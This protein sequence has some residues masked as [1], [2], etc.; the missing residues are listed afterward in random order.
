MIIRK[1]KPEEL[2]RTYELFAIAFEF[3][4]DNDKSAA[5]VFENVRKNP[6]SREDAFWGERWAAFED[7]DSTMMSFLIASPYQ[8]NFDGA[9]YKMTGI[10]GVASLPQY[11]RRGC[12]R[13]CFEAA[14]SSL[15]EE[16][17]AF[18]YLY[19][20]STAY[21]S[22]FGYGMGCEKNQ[23]HVK[24]STLKYFDV[25]GNSSLVEPDNLMLE[26]IKH[27]YQAWQNKYNMMV[28][29]EDYEYAW[30]EKSNPVRD[31]IFTYVYRNDSGE[32]MGY[33]SV[34]QVDEPDG[35]NLYCTRFCFTKVEGLKGLLNVLYSLGSSHEYV[36]LELPTDIDMT[37]I[38]PEWSMGA[39]TVK[40]TYFGMVRVVNVEAV[41]KGAQY[42]GSGSIA[43]EMRDEQIKENNGVF[44]VN[45]QNGKAVVVEKDSHVTPDISMSINDFS[46]LIMG[47]CDINSL[48]YMSGV[49]LH[50]PTVAVG[51]VF[52]RKPGYIVEAF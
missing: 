3:S 23:Y 28:I 43:I 52:Y 7:D 14:L 20:F 17:V 19:P 39:A 40:K 31:Q 51:Q 22:K 42:L 24:L 27:I 10:G 18:S 2:K 6:K 30:V 26:E 46:R 41:L 1:I 16:G 37:S 11:R 13:G 49:V 12:I 45:F 32:S 48:E 9:S 4:A 50:N 33:M 29:N 44:V 25:K 35:R 21:Y 34:K 47:A 8:V 5:E 36:T 38:F 15:Y